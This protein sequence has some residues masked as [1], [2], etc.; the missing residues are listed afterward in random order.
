MMKMLQI[1]MLLVCAVCFKANAQNTL[2]CGFK[3]VI[4]VGRYT[5][6]GKEYLT[7]TKPNLFNLNQNGQVIP[8]HYTYEFAEP[9]KGKDGVL[10][11]GDLI[12][13]VDGV[14]AKGWTKEQFYQ[15]VDGRRDVISL[16]I[17]AAI[18]RGV[19]DAKIRPLYDTPDEA[20]VYGNMF[21]DLN[22]P[23]TATTFEYRKQQL[24]KNNII[25]EILS[26]EEFDFFPCRYY[27]YLITGND[28]LLD[29]EILKKLNIKGGMERN[30]EH[31]DLLITIAKDAS[32]SIS[33]TYVPPTS[34]VVQNGSTI[35]MGKIGKYWSPIITPK[36][37][38][39]REGGYNKETKT[40]DIYLE[41]TVLDV[42]RLNDSTM[43][44]PPVVYK[45]TMKRHVLNPN[46]N[47]S[48]ELKAYASWMYLPPTIDKSIMHGPT[49]YAPLGISFSNSDPK[50][51]TEV[52]PGSRAEKAGLQPG[53]VITKVDMPNAAK[54]YRQ[55][56]KS[57]VKTQ[58]WGA[59]VYNDAIYD[60]EVM[61]EGN[62]MK[63]QIPPVSVQ[64]AYSYLTGA[65]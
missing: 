60:I 65:Q 26:D 38:T 12:L 36:Y 2:A 51:I 10:A 55:K 13:E 56:I 4:E 48:D 21:A 57:D 44:H 24:K 28:P 54:L 46:F 1:L 6:W 25:C 3:H 43:T 15:K 31:P 50:V 52:A 27:D 18:D 40:A 14:S 17:W 7:I 58:G 37:S 23:E 29:K 19:Y 39:V 59:L 47:S 34:R 32:E 62:K 49:F 41:I 33:S 9:Y 63:V 11:G 42:K 35:Q 45:A 8:L 22:G 64:G 20:K 30:E 5:N 53:D 16:K 61:T